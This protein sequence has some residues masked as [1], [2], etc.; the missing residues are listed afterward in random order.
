MVLSPCSPCFS[1]LSECRTLQVA[2]PSATQPQ[3]DS[4]PAVAVTVASEDQPAV[5]RTENEPTGE[6]SGAPQE[7]FQIAMKVLAELCTKILGALLCSA[8]LS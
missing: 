6:G 4:C 3:P 8:N 2:A 5:T 7:S 1:R